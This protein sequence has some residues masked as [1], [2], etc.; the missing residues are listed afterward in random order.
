MGCYN[1]FFKN[2]KK[3]IHFDFNLK[4]IN[5][6]NLSVK[7]SEMSQNQIWFQILFCYDIKISLKRKIS[8]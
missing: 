7:R 1:P 4:M 3:K 5:L 6:S 2:L 8:K